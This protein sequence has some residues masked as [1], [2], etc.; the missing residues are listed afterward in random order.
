[1][2]TKLV[3]KWKSLNQTVYFPGHDINTVFWYER[4][5][6]SRFQSLFEERDNERKETL[7]NEQKVEV[8]SHKQCSWATMNLNLK[9]HSI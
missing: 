5:Y 3:S 2:F 8:E 6:M 7:K 1:M 9:M 4:G